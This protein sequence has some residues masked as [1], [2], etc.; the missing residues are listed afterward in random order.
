MYVYSIRQFKSKTCVI[1]FGHGEKSFLKIFFY[2]LF[3]QDFILFRFF[4]LRLFLFLVVLLQFKDR[5]NYVIHGFIIFTT[6]LI[7]S[8]NEKMK[9]SNQYNLSF[10]QYLI[11]D[12]TSIT[13]NFIKPC[14]ALF[15]SPM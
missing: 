4:F 10:K 2:Y 12:E 8:N 6:F 14:T 1:V 15:I 13:N 9:D 7:N 5:L 11:N 3:P